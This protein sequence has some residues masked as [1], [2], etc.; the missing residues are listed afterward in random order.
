MSKKEF[1]LGDISPLYYFL[2]VALLL[3]LLFSL[4]DGEKQIPLWF[5][6]SIWLYQ[7]LLPMA[8]MIVSHKALAN[9]RWFNQQNGWLR[10]LLSGITG[11]VCFVPLALSLDMLLGFD[12]LPET[13]TQWFAA[14]ISEISGVVPPVVICWMAINAPWQLGFKLV[15]ASAKDEEHTSP[16][17][18]ED[19]A[20]D[21]T[22]S[23][24]Y[25]QAELP[26]AK[27]GQILYLKSELH[28]LLVVTTAGQTL[29][30]AN[31]KD[32][33]GKCRHLDGIQPHRS[34]WV[35][36]SAIARFKKLGRE[37]VLVLHDHTE[38]PVSR[39]KVKEVQLFLEQAPLSSLS[40]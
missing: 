15:I 6:F 29:I 3:A 36:R 22:S 23:D 8:L 14:I 7:S 34:F 11:A 17:K 16:P 20:E 30:L 1:D 9:F 28:Y 10:L 37:G 38:I 33:I 32:A 12:Q 21:K 35:S 2:A 39:S 24:R 13:N 5:N 40:P 31:L 25:L 19:K 4:I 18:I 27:R 26:A